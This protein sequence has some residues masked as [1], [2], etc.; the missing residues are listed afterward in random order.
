MR[1]KLLKWLGGVDASVHAQTKRELKALQE[2][3]VED[4]ANLVS[5]IATVQ[6]L[7]N[8]VSS[9]G[10]GLWEW[11]VGSTRVEND[12]LVV[13]KESVVEFSEAYLKMIGLGK[14]SQTLYRISDFYGWVIEEDRSKIEGAVSLMLKGAIDEF[15]LSFTMRH[16]GTG[17]PIRVR[18]HGFVGKNKDKGKKGPLTLMGIHVDETY[19][20]ERDAQ[21]ASTLRK[22]EEAS[23]EAGAKRNVFHHEVSNMTQGL[24][25]AAS[26]LNKCAKKIAESKESVLAQ[27]EAASDVFHWVSKMDEIAVAVK[28]KTLQLDSLAKDLMKFE[29]ETEIEHCMLFS[30]L[31][32]GVQD[33]E[34]AISDA[35]TVKRNKLVIDGVSGEALRQTMTSSPYP[36]GFTIER[37]FAERSLPEKAQ[38]SPALLTVLISNL[39]I[40]SAKYGATHAIVD[41]HYDEDEICVSV[42]DNGVGIK[43]E[44]YEKVFKPKERVENGIKTEGLGVGLSALKQ[45]IEGSS[46]KGSLTFTSEPGVGSKFTARFKVWREVHG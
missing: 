12:V 28:Q 20:Y 35:I 22:L 14:G 39:I 32:K 19:D 24:A 41:C 7:E 33:S 21:Y 5:H 36:E 44:D 4:S 10:W 43:K 15:T 23:R 13:D 6:L 27:S 31:E 1:Q 37:R 45:T 25:I 18:S 34:R 3:I 40:N 11:S 2:R 30:T 46:T 8:R 38:C 29:I 9:T 42:E 17:A 16:Q 26:N